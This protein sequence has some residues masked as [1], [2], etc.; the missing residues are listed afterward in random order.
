MHTPDGYYTVVFNGEIFNAPELRSQLAHHGH[1]F[2]T[3][4]SDTEVLLHL[5]RRY[6]S[7]MVDM[8]NGMFAFVVYDRLKNILFCARDP[9]GIKPF[10][11]AFKNGKFSFASELKSLR[12]L[13]WIQ[14]E[15]NCDSLNHF[16]SFQC[17]P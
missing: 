14:N 9:F 11:Y 7:S 17:V 8:L 5:Y 13:P 2:V 3:D 16:F 10:Y 6:G 4:H 1:Q 12:R 15:I